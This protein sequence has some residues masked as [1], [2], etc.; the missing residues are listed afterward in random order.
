LTEKCSNPTFTTKL[1]NRRLKLEILAPN[2]TLLYYV[3]TFSAT[4][5]YHS[6]RFS[7]SFL[8]QPFCFALTCVYGIARFWFSF[9][10]SSASHI[11]S[12]G[13]PIGRGRVWGLHY[14]MRLGRQN[15]VVYA[16][17]LT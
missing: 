3:V 7:L 12:R 16:R 17:M 5:S 11:H 14:I 2:T 1:D 10:L 15:V 13:F 9:M 4:L 6:R 8:K